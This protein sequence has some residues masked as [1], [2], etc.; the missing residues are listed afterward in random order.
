MMQ[1]LPAILTLFVSAFIIA[2]SGALMPGPL[3]TVT[4]SQAMG[5][6]ARA[7]PLLVIGHG[8]VELL[9]VSAVAL[10]ISP[11]LHQNLVLGIIGLL[12]GVF[13]I[14]MGADMARTSAEAAQKAISA[15]TGKHERT[16]D[17]ASSA[18]WHRCIFLGAV[19]SLSNPYWTLWWVTIGLSLLT[20][21][22]AISLVA[23]AAFYVGHI[24]ADLLWYWGVAFAVSRGVMWLNAKA[25]RIILLACAAFLAALGVVFVIGGGKFLF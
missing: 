21:A 6:G 10:G 18:S 2:F 19:V 17:C 7:G 5:K 12:G 3:L 1:N 25:Y 22:L 9:L 16:T 24:L 8:L 15:L 13:L 20:K 14:W 4:I 23:V 11:L